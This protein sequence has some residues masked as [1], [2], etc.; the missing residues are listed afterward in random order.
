[1]PAEVSAYL[2]SQG[3]FGIA[4]IYVIWKNMADRERAEKLLREVLDALNLSSNSN[5]KL[6]EKIS[7][8][9]KFRS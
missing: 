2:L 7:Q 1:M 9:M 3:P 6:A 5:V 4:L 8:F